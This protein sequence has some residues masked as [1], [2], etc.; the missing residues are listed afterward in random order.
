MERC[1]SLKFND[2]GFFNIPSQGCIRRSKVYIDIDFVKEE[3]KTMN[4]PNSHD[5][6]VE[7][8]LCGK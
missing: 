4:G 5:L 3:I 6:N 1:A 2:Y 7:D 8:E